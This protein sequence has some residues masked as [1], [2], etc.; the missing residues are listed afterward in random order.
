MLAEGRKCRKHCNN[1]GITIRALQPFGVPVDNIYI[2]MCACC[3]LRR[4][5]LG[6]VYKIYL[7]TSEGSF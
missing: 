6:R 1:K 3:K 5:C 4:V 2:V 7:V